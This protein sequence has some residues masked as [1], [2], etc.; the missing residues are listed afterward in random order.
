L[1]PQ[2]VGITGIISTSTD[3]ASH[4]HDLA[5]THGIAHTHDISHTHSVTPTLAY[6][7]FEGAVATGVS[8]KVNGIDRTTALGGPFSVDQAE[9]E[10]VQWLN[11]GAWNTVELTPTGLGTIIGHLRLTGYQQSI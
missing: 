11:I 8:V 6:G 1:S 2:A 10:L 4:T 5:H 9:L 3:S 7:I